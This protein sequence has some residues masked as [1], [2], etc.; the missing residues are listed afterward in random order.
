MTR[1]LLVRHG[2]S[3]WN[4]VGRWQGQADPPLTDQGRRQAQAAARSLGTV[5]LVVSSDL[6]RALV[7][8][9]IRAEE[10]GVGPVHVDADL[11]ERDAGEWSGLTRA[12]IHE[13]WPGYLPED[14][15]TSGFANRSGRRPPRWEAD[16][17]LRARALAALDR[18][19]TAVS[20]GDAL[21]ITHGGLIYAI[22]EHL[23]R[24]HERLANLGGRWVEAGDSGLVLGPR[25]LLVDPDAATVPGQI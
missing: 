14:R 11:R 6:Q 3:E 15:A 17:S 22:E 18:I 20:G 1:M 16:E 12:E 7:T 9:E 19:V 8:A 2:Q 21:V 24:G 25:V 23:G 5:D 10:L 13:Q 4:A